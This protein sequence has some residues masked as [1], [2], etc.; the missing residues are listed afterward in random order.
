MLPKP[1]PRRNRLQTPGESKFLPATT[2]KRV[3]GHPLRRPVPLLLEN[4]DL[5]VLPTDT[6]GNND[7][8]NL[9]VQTQ[10][11]GGGVRARD[12]D[13]DLLELYIREAYPKKKKAT[14]SGGN[15]VSTS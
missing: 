15:Q 7:V 2:L 14:T 11:K 6:F 13:D 8:L 12:L 5:L 3:V 1:T 9:G 4:A 10:V